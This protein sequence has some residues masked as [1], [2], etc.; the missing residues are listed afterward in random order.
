[1]SYLHFFNVDSLKQNFAK[2]IEIDKLIYEK[3]GIITE[4]LNKLKN[5]YNNLIKHNSKK[6]FLFCLDSFYFQYKI[7]NMEMEN[8]NRFII[9]IN[10]R[11]Y[12]DYYKLYNIIM[13][14]TKEKNID[15]PNAPDT[16][17]IPIYKDLEPFREYKIE[18]IQEIHMTILI[19]L[20]DM[21]SYYSTAEKR[22]NDYSDNTNVGSSIS[23]FLTTLEFEN[24]LIREQMSL[25]IN[26]IHYF[27]SSQQ[28]YLAKL[29][30]KMDMFQR[31]IDEDILNNNRKTHHGDGIESYFILS[32]ET[33][34]FDFD[35]G[36]T[37]NPIKAKESII[38]EKIQQ[39]DL[40]LDTN[41]GVIEKIDNLIRITETE[42]IHIGLQQKEST[43]ER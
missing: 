31:E 28:N 33:I 4:N 42:N 3:K 2:L 18:D 26:Y 8:L 35:D 12:G 6:I 43:E 24:T 32:H 19:L 21:Y 30:T 13:M 29:Y 15:L 23:N 10:N 5:T 7:L 22:K 37:P 9:L 40:V 39:S 25:Y 34:D 16:A 27:H 38:E 41:D 17:K 20:N 14:Q 1:M 36:F 11:M